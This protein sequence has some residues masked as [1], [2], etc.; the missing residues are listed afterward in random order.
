MIPIGVLFIGT[1]VNLKG[2]IY[3]G[4]FGAR[5]LAAKWGADMKVPTPQD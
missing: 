4:W 1:G 3:L 5:G 2:K